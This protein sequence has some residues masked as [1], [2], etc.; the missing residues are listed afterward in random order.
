MDRYLV[1]PKTKIDLNKIS[2]DHYE[3]YLGTKEQAVE[4]TKM[5]N[6]ELD[7]LQKIQNAEK[8]HKILIIFQGLDASGKDGAIRNVFG[9]VNPSGVYVAHFGAPT[10]TELSYDFLWRIHK[11]V[12]AK[13]EIV[14]FNRSHYEDVLIVRVQNLMPE[15]IWKNRFEHINNFEKMLSDEGTTI[16]KF[17]LHISYEEQR[18]RLQTRVDNPEKH[19][20]IDPQDFKDREKWGDY[21][22]AY[23]DVLQLTSTDYAPWF[24]I[25]SDKK[26]YRDLIITSILTDKLRK[27]KMKYP[28]SKFDYTGY[29]VK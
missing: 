29:V 13:G 1:K 20:K 17:Y 21:I 11:K 12:P 5:M 27:M 2:T 10:S 8:K 15:N 24:V 26:W 7:K 18:K 23:N 14:I 19:W 22:N 3:G 25:P 4:L 6:L 28:P 9:S 16:L